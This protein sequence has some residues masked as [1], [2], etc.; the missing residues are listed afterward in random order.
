MDQFHH[1]G[2]INDSRYVYIQNLHFALSVNRIVI[3]GPKKDLIGDWGRNNT[4]NFD[5]YLSQLVV[6]DKHLN[7]KREVTDNYY[8]AG[9][10]LLY[11]YHNNSLVRGDML[12]GSLKVAA[13]FNYNNKV[14]DELKDNYIYIGL[15]TPW[16]TI[17]EHTI[18]E[19]NREKD[20]YHFTDLE[21]YSSEENYMNYIK[22]LSNYKYSFITDDTCKCHVV[23]CLKLGVVPVID[24]DCRLLEIE[25]IISDEDNWEEKSKKCQDYFSQNLTVRNIS[26]RFCKALFDYTPPVVVK[27]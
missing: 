21:V 12:K 7:Y 25:D 27:K 4:T 1:K 17:L 16:I 11:D 3:F 5:L 15:Y 23:D 10:V 13:L 6:K 18:N 19:L 24:D 2:S 20:T 8:R 14:L 26:S 22:E 9:H